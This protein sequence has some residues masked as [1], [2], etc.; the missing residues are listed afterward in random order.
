MSSE[1]LLNIILGA[2]D[3]STSHYFN[4]ER[5]VNEIFENEVFHGKHFANILKREK[6][7][8]FLQQYIFNFNNTA[9][10][11]S[12]LSYMKAPSILYTYP[13][14][15]AIKDKQKITEVSIIEV[16]TLFSKTRGFEV[17][18]ER[19]VLKSPM[20]MNKNN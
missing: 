6:L 16:T 7:N 17:I 19:V 18:R 14:K 12:I 11:A 4:A 8:D 9:D 13:R 2:A 3:E 15:M 5:T 10:R 1:T 20:F